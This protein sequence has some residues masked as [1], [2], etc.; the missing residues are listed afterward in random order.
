MS[1]NIQENAGLPDVNPLD[2]FCGKASDQKSSKCTTTITNQEFKNG[3]ETKA[4]M[5][6]KISNAPIINIQ[7]RGGFITIEL[8]F[9]TAT[10][11]HLSAFWNT[12]A[13]FGRLQDEKYNDP[14]WMYV[15]TLMLVP[16]EVSNL[17]LL[18]VNPI[19][20]VLT[21]PIPGKSVS[22]ISLLYTAEN[23][24]LRTNDVE[25]GNIVEQKKHYIE[26]QIEEEQAKIEELKKKV[27][28]QDRKLTELDSYV[29]KE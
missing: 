21:A 28:E 27:E 10:N 23:V 16:I 6:N 20:W 8:N 11:P 13:E 7:R 9:Q 26:R 2:F 4:K 5:S 29:D 18:A 1:D 19:Y 3:E 17:T 12:F 14:N 15:N 24:Q 22:Q 25:T